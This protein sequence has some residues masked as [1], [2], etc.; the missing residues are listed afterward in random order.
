MA[1]RSFHSRDGLRA[2]RAG[3]ASMDNPRKSVCSA[4]LVCSCTVKPS[5]SKCAPMRVAR[6]STSACCVPRTAKLSR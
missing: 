5:P 4:A 6:A 3:P 1:M 2:T